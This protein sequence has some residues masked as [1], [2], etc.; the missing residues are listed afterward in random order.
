MPE[1]SSNGDRTRG[2][3]GQQWKGLLRA[4]RS[5]MTLFA[6]VVLV[7]TSVFAGA[8]AVLGDP[9]TFM[10]CIH[11]FLGIVGTFTMLALWCPAAL[12]HPDELK[13][14]PEGS[15]LK[16]NPLIP[17][18]VIVGAII[19]YTLYQQFSPT[20]PILVPTGYRLVS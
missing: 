20:K 19:L 8:A 12:Y 3:E 2:A 1:T 5:P 9:T 13:D 11:M 4:T 16:S 10:Y 14:V 18:L 15:L 7:C 6:L 17:T